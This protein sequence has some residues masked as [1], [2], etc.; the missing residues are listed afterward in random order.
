[1]GQ[2]YL[3]SQ[4]GGTAPQRSGADHATIAPYGPAAT[5]DGMVYFSVQSPR[6][7]V[8]FCIDV[9]QQ[10]EL[11]DDARFATNDLRVV[12]RKALS[13]VITASFRGLPT[14]EVVTRLDAAGI[15]NAELRT[16]DG[17]ANHPQLAFRDRWADVDTPV[18]PVRVLKPPFTFS[19]FTL[20]MDGVPALGANDEALR[21][22]YS[23][24]FA[25][26]DQSDSFPARSHQRTGCVRCT[27]ALAVAV[28]SNENG[29]PRAG[30]GSDA[31][32]A[33]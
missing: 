10:P 30:S 13:V 7:W 29:Q 18:G 27:E 32:L 3:Y 17:F 8:R 15:A 2:P 25:N 11:T 12:N 4:Y 1:M 24:G 26:A 6:E 20:R 16:I 5:R 9:L 22:E 23:H 14:A 19:S 21:Q 33:T 28:V 31:S